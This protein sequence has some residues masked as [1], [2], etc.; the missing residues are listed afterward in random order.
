MLSPTVFLVDM[1]EYYLD[2]LSMGDCK[3]A[4]AD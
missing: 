2:Q 4:V 1:A 3:A